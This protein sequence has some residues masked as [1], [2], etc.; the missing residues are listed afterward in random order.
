MS[1]DSNITLE[2][3]VHRRSV[4][5]AGLRYRVFV[6]LNRGKNFEGL[7]YIDFEVK[8]AEDTF[9][10]YA[11]KSLKDIVLNGKKIEEVKWEK[12]YIHLPGALLTTGKN[13]LKIHFENEYFSD[14]LGIHSYTDEAS[15]QFIHSQG[16]P[17]SSNRVFPTFDQPDLKGTFELLTRSPSK[18]A[19]ITTESPSLQTPWPTFLTQASLSAPSAETVSLYEDIRS[20][21]SAVPETE[22]GSTFT[23]F[24]VTALLPSYLF[25]IVCG[26]FEKVVCPPDLIYNSISQTLYCQ[27][28]LH[29]YAAQQAG[30]IFELTSKGIEKYEQIFGAA[31]PFSK[32]DTIYCP[33]FSSGAM[34]NPGAI[35]YNELDLFPSV[36]SRSQ[37]TDRASTILHEIAHMWFGN[38]VTMEWWDDLWLNESFADFVCYLNME[39]IRP[40]L[41]FE[42]DDPWVAMHMRKTFGYKADEAAS[43]THPIYAE[44]PDIHTTQSI[45][46]GITYSKGA[47]VLKQLYSLIGLEDFSK[48]MKVYFEKHQWKNTRLQHLLDELEAVLPSKEEG[49]FNLSKFRKDWVETAGHNVLACEWDPSSTAAAAE[50]VVRQTAYLEEYPLLRFHKVQVG[51]YGDEGK[52]LQ[53]L[54]VIVENKAETRVQYDATIGV[55]AV[56]PNFGD[57]DFVKIRV[58]TTSFEY[59]LSNFVKI[60][61]ELTKAL[62]CRCLFDMVKSADGLTNHKFLEFFTK[63]VEEEKNP[64]I[65]ELINNFAVVVLYQ[66]CSD[67]VYGAVSKLIFEPVLNSLIESRDGFLLNQLV[68]MA[69][70][71]AET[72]ENFEDL[73]KI[74]VSSNDQLA[75][76]EVTLKQKYKIAFRLHACEKYTKEEKEAFFN[77][78]AASDESGIK[79]EFALMIKG[80]HSTE[81]ERLK[82][83]Q[84]IDDDSYGLSYDALSNFAHGFTH[85][86]VKPS[87]RKLNTDYYFERLAHWI[88]SKTHEVCKVICLELMPDV[89]DVESLNKHIEDTIAKIDNKYFIRILKTRLYNNQ[90]AE[91]VKKYG[92]AK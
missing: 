91:K 49:P 53:V 48:A 24:G 70:T 11:G 33:E 46:D 1:K 77:T 12:G 89:D 9:L 13:T 30:H 47:S 78:V 40:A 73:R 28:S 65:V 69:I 35:T 66:F 82:F 92:D 79:D 38:L 6:E 90:L 34:E 26:D 3:A 17:H 15:R 75:H 32:C 25:T 51:L 64:F 36:P 7:A 61:S 86:L 76:L 43:T 56:V 2:E 39:L 74:L 23:H 85:R 42:I 54:D 10:E 84:S 67:S 80:L 55:R 5:S 16:E 21:F 37:E 87:L 83:F 29:K 31:Y 14:G 45:F 41:S 44:V 60:E 81:E 88:G 4:V 50:M 20:V 57:L 63:V 72:E 27:P 52:L 22:E 19:V 8:K 59:I 62:I 18:W 71:Y 58:D 68:E